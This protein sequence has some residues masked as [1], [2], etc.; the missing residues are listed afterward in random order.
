MNPADPKSRRPPRLNPLAPV[1]PAVLGEREAAGY[2]ARSP[3]WLRKR[4]LEDLDR[5]RRGGEPTGPMWIVVESSIAYRVAD[6]EAWLA[7]TAIEW[8]R[9]TFRG[10]AGPRSSGLASTTEELNDEHSPITTA[11][12]QAR[13][14]RRVRSDEAAAHL[15][16]RP[17]RRAGQPQDPRHGAHPA[18]P[19]APGAETAAARSSSGLTDDGEGVAP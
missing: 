19:A 3:S 17:D 11:G 15:P 4:R 9:S 5:R 1:Q 12:R 16:H 10:V 8:G 18:A 6:L 2:L 7:K 13:P 14:G